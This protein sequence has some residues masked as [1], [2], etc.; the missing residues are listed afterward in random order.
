[1]D[2]ASACAMRYCKASIITIG[3]V[4]IAAVKTVPLTMGFP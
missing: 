2:A 4:G 3:I 1:V